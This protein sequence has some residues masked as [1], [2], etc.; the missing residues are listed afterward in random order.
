MN[1]DDED[2][3]ED[4]DVAAILGDVQVEQW[5]DSIAQAMLCRCP[6]L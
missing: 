1:I 2:D 6:G 3:E 4:E 5:R